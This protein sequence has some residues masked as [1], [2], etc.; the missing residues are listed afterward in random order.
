[1]KTVCI[2]FDSLVVGLAV[3]ACHSAAA[4]TV[5]TFQAEDAA[6]LSGVTAESGPATGF[7][8]SGYADYGGIGS[9]VEWTDI[10]AAVDGDYEISIR[11]A[12]VNQRPVDVYVDGT[13]AETFDVLTAGSTWNEWTEES[14]T[15]SLAQGGHTI[16]LVASNGDGP[17]IDWMSVGGPP[18]SISRS[19]VLEPDQSME[20]GEF[21]SS[22]G[23]IFKVRCESH[24]ENGHSRMCGRF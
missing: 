11:Y 22:P 20:R 5:E 15:V 18:P 3:V 4:Q 16:K 8:G 7:S 2:N 24:V 6:T 12:A 1:M 19:T 13:K 23:G 17:N 21:R 14:V 10:S 9:F